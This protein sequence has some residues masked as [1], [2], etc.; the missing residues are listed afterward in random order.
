[1]FS[2]EIYE[3]FKTAESSLRRCSEKMVFLKISQYSNEN[4][5][6]EVFFL[7]LQACNFIKRLQYRCLPVNIVNFLRTPIVKNIWE[8]LLL[9]LP[10]F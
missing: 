1:M 3:I 5:C 4:T 8:W 10:L 2:W 7:G 6:I 9:K